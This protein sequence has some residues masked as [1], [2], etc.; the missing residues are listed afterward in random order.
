VNLYIGGAMRS[1]KNLALSA[2]YL[3]AIYEM[4]WTF[5]PTW[6]GPQSP[7]S[8]Y[9]SVIS[10]DLAT[11]WSQGWTEAIAAADMLGQLGLT[12]VDGSGSIVYYDMEHY[13]TADVSCN[14]AVQ[15][16]SAGWKQ[17][18][19][20]RGNLAG[21]YSTGSV[22]RLLTTSDH[23]PDAIWAANWIYSSYNPDAT[24]WD[25][26]RLGNDVW[27]D[28][29]RLRQY[30]GGH[31]ETWGSTK[32][33]IDSNVLDGPVALMG[34]APNTP[35]PTATP[36]STPTATATS[37]RTVVPMTPKAWFYLPLFVQE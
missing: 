15:S 21:V 7:C 36:T 37:T 9:R 24:V 31:D 18:L 13:N 26:A 32:L 30:S 8:S 29:Q 27:S 10:R 6:V 1:C 23:S 33:N 2:D 22:L 5:I 11:A 25:V 19:H 28:H 3:R 4:G 20:T 17:G 34:P 14:T 35:T 12:D 16:F